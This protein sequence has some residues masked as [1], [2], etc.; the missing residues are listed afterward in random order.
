IVG[1]L[2]M[3][4]HR[5]GRLW[6]V[7]RP[8]VNQARQKHGPRG[9]AHA[10]T[11]VALLRRGIRDP[12]VVSAVAVPRMQPGTLRRSTRTDDTP[13]TPNAPRRD[14]DGLRTSRSA[15]SEGRT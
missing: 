15:V 10:P 9:A 2:G 14:P 11:A 7:E 4:A 8:R 12:S 3:A 13:R 5:S 1:G 6:R